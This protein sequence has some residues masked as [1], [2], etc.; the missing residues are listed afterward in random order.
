VERDIDDRQ[1]AVK[2]KRFRK[3]R[4]RCISELL[5]G[6]AICQDGRAG[7]WTWADLRGATRSIAAALCDRGATKPQAKFGA[8]LWAA[9]LF[10]A[11]V[12]AHSSQ[13]AAGMLVV[14]ASPAPKTPGRKR[15]AIYE[16]PHWILVILLIIVIEV[17]HFG[18]RRD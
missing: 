6:A 16:T 15:K 7:V 2:E 9:F 10:G 5:E 8:T 4:W 14:R 17:L 12:V 11:G 3:S 13:T 1:V 18:S